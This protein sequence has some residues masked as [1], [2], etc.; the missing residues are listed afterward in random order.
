MLD[1]ITIA[2]CADRHRVSAKRLLPD[3]D[4]ALKSSWRSTDDVFEVDLETCPLTGLGSILNLLRQL[5]PDRHA[6][7]MRGAPT[8]E[9]LARGCRRVRRI[10]EAKH[11][12]RTGVADP[13][14]SR[15]VRGPGP[16]STSTTSRRPRGWT[17]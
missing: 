3:R 17:R 7:I 9:A 5:Q 13:R 11:N 8:A 10:T 16:A 1:G 4:P 2:R 14:T 6:F 12:K 15:P